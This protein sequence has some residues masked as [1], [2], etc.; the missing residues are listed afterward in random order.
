MRELFGFMAASNATLD[1]DTSA[2][3][4]GGAHAGEARRPP[5]A[6]M[7]RMRQPATA[8]AACGAAPQDGA[9]RPLYVV[10]ACMRDIRRRAD[11]TD[12]G[13]DPLRDTVR[14]GAG[15]MS[16]RPRARGAPAWPMTALSC[17]FAVTAYA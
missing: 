14:R 11:R 6:S 3:G 1:L 13:F 16:G 9:P 12:T 4:P 17:S 8:S 5:A 2:E 10:L 15:V 7:P